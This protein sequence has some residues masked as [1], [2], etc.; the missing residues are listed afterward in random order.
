MTAPDFEGAKNWNPEDFRLPQLRL[1]T[2][3]PLLFVNLDANAPSLSEMLG[4]TLPEIAERGV[5][6]DAMRFVARREYKVAC[7]WKV[8]V[9]NYQ[10]GYHVPVAHPGLLTELDYK[11]YRIDN[12]DINV[13]IPV[14]PDET[15]V[16][17]EWYAVDPEAFRPTFEARG[18]AFSEQVQFEDMAIC[19]SVQK[20][21]GSRF[22]KQGRFSPKQEAAVHRFHQIVHAFLTEEGP[23]F[24]SAPRAE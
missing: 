4:V 10:E 11:Q 6:F 1:E 22:Y 21:L 20:G 23:G 24:P 16:I 8:F 7:N 13:V 5:P 2:W 12:M 3:G 9:D 18:L 17:I 19:E 14:G 15:L